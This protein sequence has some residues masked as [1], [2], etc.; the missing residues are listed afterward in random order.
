[1]HLF[2]VPLFS[3]QFYQ[4]C[5][6]LSS[7]TKP[8]RTPQWEHLPANIPEVTQQHTSI[9]C[10]LLGKDLTGAGEQ[11]WQVA[12]AYIQDT[13][14]GASVPDGTTPHRSPMCK[15]RMVV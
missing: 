13:L 9:N 11:L 2:A 8:Q 5:Q 10:G 12:T 14:S 15:D 1:M 3:S 6:S 4:V 7:D